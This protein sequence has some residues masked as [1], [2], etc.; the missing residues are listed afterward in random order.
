MHWV[1]LAFTCH[2]VQNKQGVFINVDFLV[3]FSFCVVQASKMFTVRQIG[4]R[5]AKLQG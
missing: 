3:H 1:V 5:E 4:G 2:P